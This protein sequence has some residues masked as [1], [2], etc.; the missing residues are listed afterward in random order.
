MLQA[1]GVLIYY[2]LFLNTLCPHGFVAIQP[3]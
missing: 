3:G 1:D 2:I